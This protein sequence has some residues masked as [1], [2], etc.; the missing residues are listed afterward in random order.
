M[1]GTH[2]TSL[3]GFFFQGS[4]T[5]FSFLV[6]PVKGVNWSLKQCITTLHTY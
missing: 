4:A 2:Y 6:L 3:E 1:H 5:K